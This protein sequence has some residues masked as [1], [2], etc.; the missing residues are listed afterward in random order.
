MTALQST[1]ARL[2]AM[3]GSGRHA[4]HVAMTSMTSDVGVHGTAAMDQDRESSALEQ[5]AVVAARS[6]IESKWQIRPDIRLPSGGT[7]TRWP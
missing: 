4:L 2:R 5:L 6:A 3:P 1:N 7:G